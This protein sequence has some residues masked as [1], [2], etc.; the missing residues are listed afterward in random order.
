M[1][2]AAQTVTGAVST[3]K[4]NSAF[5][6]NHPVFFILLI[7]VCLVCLIL[8]SGLLSYKLGTKN[9]Y[10]RTLTAIVPY[11]AAVVNW[12]IIDLATYNE[13]SEVLEN[14]VIKQ[15]GEVTAETRA[16]IRSDVLDKLIQEKIIMQLANK[17][18]VKLSD[19]DI[20][21]EKQKI[22]D[23]VGETKEEL[24]TKL[25]DAYGWDFD[26]FFDKVIKVSVY[27]QKVSEQFYQD[28]ARTK[29]AEKQAK[30]VLRL[31]KKGD[32]QFQDLAKKYSQDTRTAQ[33][34]GELGWVSRGDLP[35]AVEQAAFG[36]EIGDVSDLI[37]AESGYHIIKIGDKKIEGENQEVFV[38]DM[39]FPF[40]TFEDYLKDYIISSKVYRFV[41]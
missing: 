4:K 28:D 32:E 10:L 35:A 14:L 5:R 20:E 8:A 31:V 38:Y 19:S 26:T 16:D 11:P 13:E 29:D 15:Q 34:G 27:Q 21:A 23:E 33:L 24:N 22:I 3:A 1:E 18:G 2:S 30:D 6:Y 39:F 37:K 36:M 25:Q 40:P 17:F 7:L 9:A 41:K 12:D